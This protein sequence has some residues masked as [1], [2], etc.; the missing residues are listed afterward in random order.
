M[1]YIYLLLALLLAGT[2]SAITIDRLMV[3]NV[4]I[5][6]TMDV[7]DDY[8]MN[9]FYPELG[10]RLPQKAFTKTVI[11]PID[12]EDATLV[13]IVITD[14]DGNRVVKHRYI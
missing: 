8:T 11:M 7:R 1:K 3:D 4:A 5:I 10:V 2:A 13:R 12:A 6:A 9:V 14:E